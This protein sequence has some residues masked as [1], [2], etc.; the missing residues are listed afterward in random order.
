MLRVFRKKIEDGDTIKP[1]I[2]PE[3]GPGPCYKH[4]HNVPLQPKVPDW[5]TW[6]YTDGSS[7]SSFQPQRIGAGVYIP[8]TNTGLC[9]H[10]GGV[11]LINTIYRAE[12]AAIAAALKIQCSHIATDSACAL[13]QIRKQLLYPEKQRKHAHA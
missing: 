12:L 8:F 1:L 13:S 7:L 4:R 5:H 6:A 9:L 2:L 10:F 11:G 3:I